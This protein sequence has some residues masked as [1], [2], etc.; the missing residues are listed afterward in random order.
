MSSLSGI[1]LARQRTKKCPT[2]EYDENTAKHNGN[3]K[4]ANF[5]QRMP[6]RSFYCQANLLFSTWVLYNYSV[7]LTKHTAILS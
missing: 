6:I 1:Q 2:G 3:G 7:T 4:I 5:G